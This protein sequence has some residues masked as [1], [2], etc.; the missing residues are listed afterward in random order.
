MTD[1][2]EQ[3][4]PVDRSTMYEPPTLRT[5][6]EVTIEMPAGFG[7]NLA[8]KG[9]GIASEIEKA[10]TSVSGTATHIRARLKHIGVEVPPSE[11]ARVAV[12]DD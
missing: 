3:L 8:R 11:V 5:I 6:V 10:A 1:Q 4:P 9:E 12:R 2:Q 7:D